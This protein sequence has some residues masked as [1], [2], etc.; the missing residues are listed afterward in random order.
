LLDASNQALV[1][2]GL[3]IIEGSLLELNGHG[4]PNLIGLLAVNLHGEK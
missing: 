3:V 4:A 1:G 2:E